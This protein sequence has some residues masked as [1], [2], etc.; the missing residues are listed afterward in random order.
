MR[1]VSSAFGTERGCVSVQGSHISHWS[2]LSTHKLIRCHSIL[3]FLLFGRIYKNS[4]SLHGMRGLQ[5]GAIHTIPYNVE[6][7]I[8][9]QS[10]GSSLEYAVHWWSTEL[11]AKGLR[12]HMHIRIWEK[13]P[14]CNA[15]GRFLLP[16]L[17]P[18]LDYHQSHAPH[19]TVHS[20]DLMSGDETKG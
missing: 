13:A 18:I 14:G 8:Y 19:P 15:T 2:R 17:G 4:E 9:M 16:T 5:L 20:R 12:G 7:T 10:P 1:L 3:L 6:N 11:C